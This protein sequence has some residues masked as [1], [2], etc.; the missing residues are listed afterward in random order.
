MLSEYVCATYSEQMKN[1]RRIKE[2]GGIIDIPIL[3]SEVYTPVPLH[4]A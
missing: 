2:F 4:G 3:R 1:G